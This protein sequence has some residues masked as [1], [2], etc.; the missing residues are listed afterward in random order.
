[1]PHRKCSVFQFIFGG[2][3]TAKITTRNRKRR[4]PQ[5]RPKRTDENYKMEQ[6]R[7]YTWAWWATLQTA[8]AIA[9]AAVPLLLMP[10]R[11]SAVHGLSSFICRFSAISLNSE[12]VN[13]TINKRCTN[14]WYAMRQR[15]MQE[16]NVEQKLTSFSNGQRQQ[17]H[18]R[19]YR[20]RLVLLLLR[21]GTAKRV[22]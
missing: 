11:W 15:Q 13:I 12:T 10:I 3:K 22:M 5:K 8:G 2:T 4:V 19:G 14:R 6:Q 1:M 20:C 18:V 16:P 9:F 21:R 17:T 7:E